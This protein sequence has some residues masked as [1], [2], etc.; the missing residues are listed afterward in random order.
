LGI[1]GQERERDI[2]KECDIRRTTEP[3]MIFKKKR[4]EEV[5]KKLTLGYLVDKYFG[6][7]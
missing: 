5:L 6:I 3:K 7:S 2:E 1:Q 4:E